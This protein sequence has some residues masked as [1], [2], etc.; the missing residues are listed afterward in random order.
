MILTVDY[1]VDATES[2]LYS[3]DSSFKLGEVVVQPISTYVNDSFL[4]AIRNL[5]NVYDAEG[6]LLLKEQVKIDNISIPLSIYGSP[7]NPRVDTIPGVNWE[8]FRGNVAVVDEGLAEKLGLH[9]GSNLTVHGLTFRVEYISSIIWA[10]SLKYGETA[11]IVVPI[12]F[13]EEFL[14]VSN[15]YNEVR[16]RLVDRALLPVTSYK[17]FKMASDWG[18]N[19]KVYIRPF[20]VLDL[21]F[22]LQP[23]LNVARLITLAIIVSTTTFFSY[24]D[25]RSRLR[26]LGVLK[27]LGFSKGN[28]YLLYMIQLLLAGVIASISSIYL[29]KFL[30]LRI[31]KNISYLPSIPVV[32][33]IFDFNAILD[34][35]IGLLAVLASSLLILIRIHIRPL[36]ELIKF[37]DVDIKA[38]RFIL[39]KTGFFKLDY[40][41]RTISSRKI[42]AISIVILV[43]LS[44]ALTGAFTLLAKQS[45]QRSL[46]KYEKNFT[47][48]VSIIFEEP[49]N[50]SIIG[51]ISKMQGIEKVEPIIEIQLPTLK[52]VGN[53][54]SLVPPYNRIMFFALNGNET[55]IKF[56]FTEGDL[57]S[58]IVI[59]EKIA[60]LLNLEIGDQIEIDAL[61]P[62]GTKL[63]VSV[64]IGGIVD[65]NVF[66][67]WVL[68]MSMEYVEDQFRSMLGEAVYNAILI[69]VNDTNYVPQL[70]KE[71]SDYLYMNNIPAVIQT[72][73]KVIKGVREYHDTVDGIL[74]AVIAV[75][76][77]GVTLSIT[78]IWV[79]DLYN[80]RWEI[81]LYRILG[82]NLGK[83]LTILSTEAIILSAIAAVLSVPL[84]ATILQQLTYMLNHST[85]DI[86]IKTVYRPDQLVNLYMYALIVPILIQ[87]LAIIVTHR[88]ANIIQLRDRD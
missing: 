16:V 21:L 40:A 42:K 10:P 39:F 64:K 51:D 5:E 63:G 19:V 26:E 46:E 85:L 68:I 12:D 48:D 81:V 36:N 59:T 66:G 69:R 41:L 56:D 22:N 9:K 55:M 20:N 88:K 29:S 3:L 74:N 37:G 43:T 24:V 4:D 84:T 32:I 35:G 38:G 53:G 54:K 31:I 7:S 77:F 71:L 50:K 13:L 23:I 65:T 15:L 73:E 58:G 27:S 62:M 47:W 60:A 28:I 14:N 18:L 34:L 33:N 86:W 52:I 80:R 44:V 78:L 6:F 79:I 61:H 17:I 30:A 76:M 49:V 2:T 8:T 67:G 82:S 45:T 72:R 1:L 25:V 11:S 83:T 87:I 70:E 75:I 57:N